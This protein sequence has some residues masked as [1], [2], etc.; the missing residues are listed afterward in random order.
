MND[1]HLHLILN[2]FPIIG[3]IVGTLVLGIGFLLSIRLVRKTGIYI[4]LGA[5][6]FAFPSNFTGEGAEEI[7]EELPGISHKIIHEHEELAE[8]FLWIMIGLGILCLVS[9]ILDYLKHKLAQT[10]SLLTLIVACIAVFY[11][12]QVG[13]SGGEIRH[14]EMKDTAVQSPAGIQETN[15]ED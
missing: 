1:A 3:S 14:P 4:L 13:L 12:A 5:A 2:H 8:G 10:V 7:V 11:G 9:L 15:Q 6:L